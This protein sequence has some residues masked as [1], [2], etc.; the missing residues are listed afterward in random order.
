MRSILL[1][2]G[3]AHG[4]MLMETYRNGEDGADGSNLAGMILY[5][6]VES[7]ILNVK[8]IILNVKAVIFSV[9]AIIL[10]GVSGSPLFFLFND[11]DSC[12]FHVH[13][14][15]TNISCRIFQPLSPFKGL[16]E[17]LAIISPASSFYS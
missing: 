5:K 2:D 7:A 17:P 8:G 1:S 16:M 3:T 10:N 14:I 15:E 11:L 4:N 13:N 9:K 12:V 6:T